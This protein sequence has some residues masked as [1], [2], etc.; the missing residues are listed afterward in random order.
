MDAV[1]REIQR[2]RDELERKDRGLKSANDA[3][4]Y[5]LIKATEANKQVQEM[6]NHFIDQELKHKQE[7]TDVLAENIRLQK[8]VKATEAARVVDQQMLR[9]AEEK[10]RKTQIWLD[11]E[12]ADSKLMSMRIK[13]AEGDEPL[14]TPDAPLK[15]RLRSETSK[16]KADEGE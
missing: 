5:C 9:E 11:Q 15:S 2:L 8:E 13:A 12:R 3:K 16:R 14:A 7:Y 10:A 4:V 1:Q 6:K